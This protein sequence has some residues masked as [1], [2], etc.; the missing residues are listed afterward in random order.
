MSALVPLPDPGDIDA[1][2]DPAGAICAYVGPATAWLAQA[3]DL[4][5]VNEARAQANGIEAYARAKG[6]A[7]EAVRSARIIQLRACTALGR[8]LPKQTAGRGKLLLDGNNFSAPERSKLRKLAAHPDVVEQAI[9]EAPTDKL[10]PS[11]VLSRIG[12]HQKQAAR[13]VVPGDF[14][15][16][17]EGDEREVTAI[18]VD[19]NE[20]VLFDDEGEAIIVGKNKE[21]RVTKPDLGEGISHPAR[22]SLPLIPIFAAALPTYPYTLVLDPFAGTGRIHELPQATVGVEIEPEWAA[23]HPDTQVGS[24]LDLQFDDEVFDAVCTSPCYGNRFA[25][26][27]DAKDGSVRRS[28]THDLG[29]KLSPDSAG[30]LQ[31]GEKYRTFHTQAWEEAWRVLKPGGR[32]VLNVKDHDRQYTRQY[33]TAWHVTELMRIGFDLRWFDQ[34]DTG[35]LHQGENEGRYPEQIIVFDKP[36]RKS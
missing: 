7:D 5:Q 1:S 16:D 22:F 24:A 15:V 2:V 12:K 4:A 26:S 14:V 8:L 23:L 20:V 27:H 17:D 13:D 31:W 18:E 34:L 19:G 29:R 9:A 28:Y 35:G 10:S 21:V 33:V 36:E 25:D 3:S 11:Q 6:L 32:L 30:S